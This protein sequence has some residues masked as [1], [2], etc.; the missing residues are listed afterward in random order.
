LLI[1]QFRKIC[2]NSKNEKINKIET[3]TK[4]LRKTGPKTKKPVKTSKNPL[5]IY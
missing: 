1:L 4:K 3:K 5:I 2:S